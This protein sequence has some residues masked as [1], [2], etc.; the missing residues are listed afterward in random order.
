MKNICKLNS[1]FQSKKQKHVRQWWTVLC[2]KWI[3][4]S[5]FLFQKLHSCFFGLGKHFF[6]QDKVCNVSSG[7]EVIPQTPILLLP[8]HSHLQWGYI[9]FLVWPAKSYERWGGHPEQEEMVYLWVASCDPRFPGGEGGGRAHS[10][11]QYYPHTQVPT[12]SCCCTNLR[13]EFTSPF[14][15]VLLTPM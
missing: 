10:C 13:P 4:T 7:L 1:T 14:Q 15:N 9:K 11:W 6:F 8:I 2:L 12:N 5:D 3:E